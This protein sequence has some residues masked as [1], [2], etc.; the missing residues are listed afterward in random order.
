[1]FRGTNRQGRPAM[2]RPG[3]GAGCLNSCAT[4]SEN[5]PDTSTGRR[6]VQSGRKYSNSIP[7]R[8]APAVCRTQGGVLSG[9][10][11]HVG[12]TNNPHAACQTP[13]AGGAFLT[14]FAES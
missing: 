7:A 8:K 6:T 13:D 12:A 11:G 3:G 10:R 5:Q 2:K 4:K 9:G 1:M 14:S